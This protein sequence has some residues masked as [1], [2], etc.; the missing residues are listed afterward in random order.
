MRW[1]VGGYGVS[2]WRFE[3]ILL[4]C[5]SGGKG[6]GSPVGGGGTV[7]GEEGGVRWR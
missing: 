3:L 6:K 5:F 4:L 7:W 2:D 1:G